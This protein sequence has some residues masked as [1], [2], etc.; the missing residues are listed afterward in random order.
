MSYDV[1]FR[2]RAIEYHEEGNSIRAT[3]KTFGISPNTFNTWLQK[4]RKNGE[5]E[6]KYRNYEGK[7]SEE[8]LLEH[9]INNPDAY[10]S[11]MAEHFGSSQST[12]HRTMKRHN[13][14]RKKRRE[15]TGSNA[16]KE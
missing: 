5:L 13:I 6:R 14:T 2:K 7:I 8:A 16:P 9:L 4:Y 12:I 1:K 15:D 10:Q 11:E 3:A